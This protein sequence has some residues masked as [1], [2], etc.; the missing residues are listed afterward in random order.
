MRHIFVTKVSVIALAVAIAACGGGS[1]SP[2]SPTTPFSTVA[3]VV[4]TGTFDLDA[5]RTGIFF[6][7]LVTV[8]D[9]S[10]GKWEATVDWQSANN[11]LW[12]WVADGVCT[13]D[14]FENSACPSSAACPCKF[15]VVSQVATPKPRVLTIEN[16]SGGTR[17]LI[18]GNLGPSGEQAQYR[19]TLSG[20]G[21][22]TTDGST[23]GGGQAIV[24]SGSKDIR[25]LQLPQ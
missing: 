3:R 17:T 10:R 20:S 6:F 8:T 22:Q 15:S 12:M 9:P 21:L 25:S 4:Q 19:V 7:D 16:A 23:R 11:T 2:S 14:Q 5:P 18:V 13:A 1:G 24:S